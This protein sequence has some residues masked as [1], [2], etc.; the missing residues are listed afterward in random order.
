[1]N[2]SL[3]PNSIRHRISSVDISFVKNTPSDTFH[4]YGWVFLVS[5]LT[6]DDNNAHGILV[7]NVLGNI[8]LKDTYKDG[9]ILRQMLEKHFRKLS[10]QFQLILI[11]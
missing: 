6:R 2:T 11:Y 7:A 3:L 10:E 1:M 4:V 8:L 5:Y 9:R